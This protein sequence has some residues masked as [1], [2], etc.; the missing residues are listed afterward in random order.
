MINRRLLSLLW[1]I[2]LGIFSC[3]VAASD[4][5]PHAEAI[6]S[7]SSYATDAGINILQQ[8]GN[9]FDA[10]VAVATMLGVT[11]AYHSGIGGGGFILIYDAKRDKYHFIDARETA[12]Q[13]ARANMYLDSDGKLIHGASLNG[14]LSAAIPGVPAG[15]DYLAKHYGNLPL[16]KTVAPAI[17]RASTGFKVDPL[18]QKHLQTRLA[19]LRQSPAAAAIFLKD[20]QMPALGT[21][22]KQP[23]LADTLTQFANQGA[24]GFYRGKVAKKMVQGVRAAGGVW[25]E[26][27]LKKYRVIVRAPLVGHYQGTTVVTAP[28]PSAG[29]VALISM[30]NM[31]SHFDLHSVTDLTRMQL[32]VE[33][34]RRA[35][36]DRASFLG[37]PAYV[38]M[39][40]KCLLSLRHAA[41]LAQTIQPNTATP[42][43]TLRHKQVENKISQHT[44]HFSIIDKDGNMVAATLSINYIFG[45]GFVPPGTGVLL[46]DE[47]NDFSLKQSARNVY[48][49]IGSKPNAIAPKKRPIS[50]MTPT[51]LIANDRIGILGVPG[52]S[53]I[54]TMVLLAALDFAN[55]NL[56]DSWVSLPR[57]H[58]QYLPDEIQFE[59][60]SI[61]DVQQKQLQA[62]GYQLNELR[63]QYGNMQAILWDKQN[64]R[65]YAAS[66]PR[67]QGKATVISH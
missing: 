27:D 6:A 5:K 51:F 4:D 61:T 49:V 11:E 54:P 3:T 36:W 42:S 32:I 17:A 12:P 16:T 53:R 14:P 23:D 9:A 29:G 18:Y 58:H 19:V 60:N 65:L 67:Y 47:M 66:D 38:M 8:G 2:L 24:N 37:D 41:K 45:S 59:L 33:V 40:I 31:L 30:L 46:N 43:N 39:P 35:F 1:F 55:G 57:F 56:P 44:T 50:S 15:L 63:R 25:T 64:D 13:A 48:G 10:A 22:I 28:P 21:V 7:A 62:M 20:Q 34:M 26:S 52:G